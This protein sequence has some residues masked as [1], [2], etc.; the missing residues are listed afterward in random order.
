MTNESLVRKPLTEQLYD[1][2]KEKIIFQELKCGEKINI[3]E[4]S[5]SYGV[6]IT[7][8]RE[9][10]NRLSQEGLVEFVPN[11]GAKVFKMN[12]ETLRNINEACYYFEKLAFDYICENN[13]IDEVIAEMEE[14]LAH[15]SEA[16]E[17][18]DEI[19]FF[20][21]SKKFHEIMI[22]R[23]DNEVLKKPLYQIHGQY[24][25]ANK[26]VYTNAE[27]R[28]NSVK[29]H[30]ELLNELKK[31]KNKKVHK[32]LKSHYFDSYERYSGYIFEHI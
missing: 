28:K 10:I 32:L 29:E 26:V 14:I 24:N 5:K 16:D 25:I 30:T 6:S 19:E 1:R 7:P 17:K 20:K 18:G 27:Y 9:A 4:L 2:I 3:D 22:S 15:Q 31:G 8:V 11:V 13:L 23:I 12:E 21:N